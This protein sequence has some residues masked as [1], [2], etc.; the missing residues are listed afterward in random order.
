MEATTVELDARLR[1]AIQRLKP[2]EQALHAA[3]DAHTELLSRS[4][5]EARWLADWEAAPLAK[6]GRALQ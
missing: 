3:A 5:E 1:A 4:K 2:R 6:R